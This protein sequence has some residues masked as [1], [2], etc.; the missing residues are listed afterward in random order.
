MNVLRSVGLLL[1]ALLPA[2][3][4]Q[5]QMV[6]SGDIITQEVFA[7]KQVGNG[8][9]VYEPRGLRIMRLSIRDNGDR[10][11]TNPNGGNFSTTDRNFTRT[12][13][14]GKTIQ[15]DG[16]LVFFEK[17]SPP[18][19]A[20][21]TSYQYE[22]GQN[23]TNVVQLNAKTETGP[24]LD[25]EVDGKMIKVPTVFVTYEGFISSSMYPWKGKAKFGVAYSPDLGEIVYSDCVLLDN[26][27]F[28][29]DGYKWTV[30]F[31]HTVAAQAQLAGAATD[32][33]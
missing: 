3:S 16:R 7:A 27:G 9:I 22:A 13:N 15:A 25:I 30:K 32:G 20:S 21:P 14:R 10:H 1:V 24:V 19:P 26:K 33:K 4:V 12:V 23:G 11:Y 5:A 31:V 17:M 8:P 18:T 6:A 28:L 29:M 2:A